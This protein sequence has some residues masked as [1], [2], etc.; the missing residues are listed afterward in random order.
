MI[1]NVIGEGLVE[2]ELAWLERFTPATA[3]ATA[4]LPDLSGERILVVCHL[5]RRWCRCSP[6]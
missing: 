1:G 6:G 2:A 4:A 3:R 5:D